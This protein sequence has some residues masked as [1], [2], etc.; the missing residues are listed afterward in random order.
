MLWKTKMFAK[1]TDDDRLI[2]F[3]KNG[4]IATTCGTPLESPTNRGAALL[5]LVGFVIYV[6]VRT[7]C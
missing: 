6:F 2:N 7:G 3:S 1:I 5:S 4:P